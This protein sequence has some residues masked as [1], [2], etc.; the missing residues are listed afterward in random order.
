MGIHV[1]RNFGDLPRKSKVA[2][3]QVFEGLPQVAGIA[4]LFSFL[5]GLCDEEDP[6]LFGFDAGFDLAGDI[7][8][9]RSLG[10]GAP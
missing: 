9:Y 8:V 6:Q 3:I 1:F 5:G 4:G 10:F 7:A 2:V